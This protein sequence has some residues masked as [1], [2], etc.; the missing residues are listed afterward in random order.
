MIIARGEWRVLLTCRS[1]STSTVP[2]LSA[3]FLKFL[4][5]VSF[6]REKESW[7][8]SGHDPSTSAHTRHTSL[9]RVRLREARTQEAHRRHSQPVS[10]RRFFRE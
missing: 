9:L 5:S 6:L 10:R 1:P 3:T 7:P 4:A 8:A 2:F